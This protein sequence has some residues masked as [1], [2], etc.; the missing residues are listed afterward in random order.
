MAL[1]V[2]AILTRSAMRSNV[3]KFPGT[4]TPP[5]A[6]PYVPPSSRQRFPQR[7]L[8]SD[9]ACLAGYAASAAL[10]AVLVLGGGTRHLGFGIVAFT[11]LAAV[12]G[13][14]S[15][16]ATAACTAVIAWMFFDG[17]LAGRHAELRWHGGADIARLGLLLAAAA[18]A[19]AA[20]RLHARQLTGA[21]ARQRQR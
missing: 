13:W 15:R 6:T 1:Q 17:F 10:T 20:R 16:S 12:I 14:R 18:L 8:R 9:E 7:V 5:H 3:V 2:A 19:S 4:R 21:A 11:V